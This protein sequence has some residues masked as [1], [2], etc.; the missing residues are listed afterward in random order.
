M[1][2]GL[3]HTLKRKNLQMKLKLKLLSLFLAASTLT[4]QAFAGQVNVSK[5][6]VNLESGKTSDFLVLHNDS[7]EDKESYEVTIQKWTQE[8]NPDF[9][10]NKELPALREVLLPT[11]NVLA[12]PKTVVLL[13]KQDK[14]IRI[15]VTDN[16][17]AQ[18]D[19][20]YR[21][22]ITQLPASEGALKSSSI[23]LLFKISLPVFVYQV[24]MDNIEKMKITTTLSSENGKTYLSIKNNDLQ[25]I[26]IQSI[27]S[28]DKTASLNH[29]VLPGN[30]DIVE[31][32]S[33]VKNSKNNSILN[34]VTDKG[35]IKINK[36]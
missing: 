27:E 33:Q 7:N 36:Q 11:E 34:I 15:M 26:Q 4:V 10:T 29:Y 2:R 16:E 5:L 21:L 35:T 20:S 25:H 3:I 17:K 19:Y 31:L 6:R 23:K 13:P 22:I 18:K 8:I 32:P 12:S 14:I 28:G 9:S 24:A 1:L 30:T